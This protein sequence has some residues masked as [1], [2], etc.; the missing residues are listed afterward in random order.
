M[1]ESI[2]LSLKPKKRF[3]SLKD[4]LGTSALQ[5]TI[6]L[7]FGI[8]FLFLVPAY[9]LA[10]DMNI[11]TYLFSLEYAYISTLEEFLGFFVAMLA[12][13]ILHFIM[14]FILIALVFIISNYIGKWLNLRPLRSKAQKTSKAIVQF[15]LVILSIILLYLYYVSRIQ[16]E[17]L[18]LLTSFIHLSNF[19]M[20]IYI[21]AF[22]LVCVPLIFQALGVIIND[23]AF[24]FYYKI[25]K[26]RLV[27]KEIEE[28]EF[29]TVEEYQEIVKKPKR[30]KEIT[31]KTL[32]V[33]LVI[34]IIFSAGMFLKIAVRSNSAYHIIISKDIQCELFYNGLFDNWT[35]T[36]SSI[37]VDAIGVLSTK[38]PYVKA[39]EALFFAS[40][41]EEVFELGFTNTKIDTILALHPEAY[42]SDIEY[43]VQ[44]PRGH[45]VFFIYVWATVKFNDTA[46]AKRYIYPI[47][48][49]PFSFYEMGLD[50][51]SYLDYDLNPKLS[52]MVNLAKC[53]WNSKYISIHTMNISYFG[54]SGGDYE[55]FGFGYAD[56]VYNGLNLVDMLLYW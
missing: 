31:I 52:T 41:L 20:N 12:Y 29:V 22:F 32:K 38:E 10:Y 8:V 55:A 17:G 30:K 4:L 26:K 33:F 6:F 40:T 13:I 14:L 43:V 28:V 34:F 18:Y 56:M 27:P 7:T 44:I 45:N 15:S 2:E 35:N 42:S 16:V 5:I 25:T 49:S 21:T 19:Y 50:P 24:Y 47:E 37:M 1:E 3:S 9:F 53:D 54:E 46:T 23:V 11:I 48:V 36:N 39:L 51:Y